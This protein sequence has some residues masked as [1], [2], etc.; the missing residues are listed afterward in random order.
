[1]DLVMIAY[2][3][4]RKRAITLTLS[5]ISYTMLESLRHLL[6]IM[7]SKKLMGVHARPVGSTGLPSVSL[8]LIALGRILLKQVFEK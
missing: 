3:H 2:I 4:G 7:L 1:M 6:L 5:W 8:F